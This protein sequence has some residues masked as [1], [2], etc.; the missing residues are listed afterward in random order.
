MP[1]DTAHLLLC[2]Y[3]SY[4]SDICFLSWLKIF[5]KKHPMKHVPCNHKDT[6]H[7][8]NLKMF[9]AQKCINLKMF[10][11]LKRTNLNFS[12]ETPRIE[13]HSCFCSP[14]SYHER[15]FLLRLPVPCSTLKCPFATPTRKGRIRTPNCLAIT[16]SLS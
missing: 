13:Y 9:L 4:K 7:C 12:P 10:S 15:L 1:E 14:A 5:C 8:T 16:F 3:L 2:A 11:A 6:I